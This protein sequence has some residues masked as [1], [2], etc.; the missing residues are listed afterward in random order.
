MIDEALHV[1]KIQEWLW[2]NVK[3]ELEIF[4]IWAGTAV[5]IELQLW[6]RLLTQYEKSESFILAI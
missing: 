3:I 2:M 1:F 6:V 5:S 4:T